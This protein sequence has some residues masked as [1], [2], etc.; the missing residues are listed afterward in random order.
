MYIVQNCAPHPPFPPHMSAF[1]LPD[2]HDT[3]TMLQSGKESHCKHCQLGTKITSYASHNKYLKVNNNELLKY[4]ISSMQNHE[5]IVQ[6]L[7]LIKVEI[8]SF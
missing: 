3:E 1:H 5:I 8:S 6:N 7:P 4:I 2:A